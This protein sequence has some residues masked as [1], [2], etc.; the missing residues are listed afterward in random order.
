[1]AE[2]KKYFIK[3]PGALVEVSAEVYFTYFRVRR[4]WFAQG[5]RDTYNGVVSYDAMDTEEMLGEEA[6]PDLDSPSVEDTVVNS[7]L[8]KKLHCCLE[9]LQQPEQDML[10]A[11]YFDGL[12]ERQVA[13]QFGVHHMTIHNR[14]IKLLRKLKKMMDK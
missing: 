12:S 11:L 8:Q 9:Q 10:Y 5:E 4:R 3:V 6:I 2:E 13:A 1:M 7:L 14:K